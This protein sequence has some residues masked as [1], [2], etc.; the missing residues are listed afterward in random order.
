M[1]QDMDPR[2]VTRF[3]VRRFRSCSDIRYK[4]YDSFS[5]SVPEVVNSDDPIMSQSTNDNIDEIVTPKS[6]ESPGLYDSKF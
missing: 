6:I 1:T 4:G 3:S 5:E 2:T